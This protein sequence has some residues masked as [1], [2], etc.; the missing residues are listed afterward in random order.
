MALLP[1]FVTILTCLSLSLCVNSK[2]CKSMDIRNHPEMLERLRGCTVI[3]GYLQI[4]L[5]ELT[6]HHSESFSLP[7]LREVTGYV[8]VFRVMNLLSLGKLFPNLA[9]IRGDLLFSGC[10]LVLH[11]M[12]DL[13]EVRHTD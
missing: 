5:M 10:A 8:L 1:H 7:E 12:P 11:D 6:E 9:I 2:V 4:G 13:E 3:Q